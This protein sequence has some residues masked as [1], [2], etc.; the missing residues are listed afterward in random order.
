MF[1]VVVEQQSFSRAAAVLCVSQPAVSKGIRE[2]ESQLDLPL[3]DRGSG[4][5]GGARGIVL[6]D[7]G[8]ALYEHARGIF[9]MERVALEDI[10]DRVELRRGRLRVGAS[11]TVAAYCLS[12]A[13]S[14][15]TRRHPQ[16]EFELKVGNTDG[17]SRLIQDGQID[18][19]FVEGQVDIAGVVATPWR[20][21]PLQIVAAADAPLA[22]APRAAALSAEPWLVREPGSGTRQAAE[23]LLSALG[24]SPA[25]RIEIGSNEAI[26]QA[27]ACGAGIAVLPAVV[28]ADLVAIGRVR[29]LKVPGPAQ[30]VRPLYRLELNNRPRTPALTA[31]LQQ[32]ASV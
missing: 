24:V 10:R 9:A 4:V 1:R 6:T 7:S 16:I 8:R 32:I 12:D 18:V 21:D 25:L 31:F 17:I 23:A 27:V 19:A 22:R 28:V 15:F 30:S 14:R 20:Q 11:T 5:A 13:V 26:A 3:I 29:V 2:L